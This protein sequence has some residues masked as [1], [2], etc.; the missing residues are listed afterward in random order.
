MRPNNI[1][2]K[3]Y[4]HACY[5]YQ[6]GECSTIKEVSEVVSISDGTLRRRFS[7]DGIKKPTSLKASDLDD[8]SEQGKKLKA[9]HLNWLN[10]ITRRALMFAQRSVTE[11]I[12][13]GNFNDDLKALKHITDITNKNYAT[14]AKILNV[15]EI[16]DVEELP[17]FKVVE[18]TASDV[19]EVRKAQREQFRE[20]STTEE[21]ESRH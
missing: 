14:C 15:D 1:D 8:S 11:N 9:D 21:I 13:L 10:N 19:E 5:L 6:S 4:E 3:K 16:V 2:Q 17:E 12:P 7:E 20:L 18:M